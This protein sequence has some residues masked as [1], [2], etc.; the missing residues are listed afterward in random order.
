MQV[1]IM[2]C[3]RSGSALASRLEAEGDEVI[4][5]DTDEN[6]ESRLPAGFKGHF[7]HGSGTSRSKLELAG[8]AHAE[9]F[10]ALSPSDSANIVAARSAREQFKVPRVI[11]RL[12]DPARA[13][14]YAE[15]GISTVGSVQT[16]VNRVHHLLHHRGLE[17]EQ[18]FGN[19]ETMLMRSFVPDYLAGRRVAELN[20]AGEIQV[21]EISRAGHSSIPEGVSV[22]QTGDFVSFIVASGSLGRLRGFLDGSWH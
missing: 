10:V 1:I 11:S 16:N 2:G 13:P 19:G 22:L 12:Y 8:I 14:I 4:L 7:I 9:A 15:L 5:L 3:G 20:V 6:A 21:V 18:T 17:P